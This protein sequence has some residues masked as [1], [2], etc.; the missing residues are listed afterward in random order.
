MS[1][2]LATPAPRPLPHRRV[3]PALFARPSLLP[4]ALPFQ[5]PIDEICEQ[6]APAFLRGTHYLVVALFLAL[7]LIAALT[8]VD[9]VVVASGRIATATPPIVLQPMERAIVRELRVRPGD[10]VTKGEVLATLDP[11]FAEADA[12]ALQTQLRALWA[13]ARRLRAEADGQPLEAGAAPEAD[14]G[15]QT[16]L[17]R[18]RQAEYAARVN[19][20]DA[21]IA[22]LQA[23]LRTLE[24]GRGA[25]GRELDVARAVEDMRSA[26]V[27]SQT[28]SRLNLLEAQAVRLRAERDQLE[29]ANRLPELRH[30]IQ[31][32]EAERQSFIDGWRRDLLDSLVSTRNDIARAVAGLAKAARLHD[33]VVVTAPVDGVVLDVAPR[34]EGSVLRE[35]EPLL[36]IVPKDAPLIAE[37]MIASGDVGYTRAGAEAQIK[38]DAFP[39]QRHGMVA[40]RL[41]SVGE[42]SFSAGAIPETAGGARGG[43]LHRGR[44]ELLDMRLANLPTGARLFPGMTLTAEIKAGSRSVLSYFLYPLTRGLSESV[45]EP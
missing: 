9:V 12:A 8:R 22:R 38:V 36:T 16:A 39:Y 14:D 43:A 2:P 23:S 27:Q 26:L 10:V 1:A 17:Y 4:E 30:G 37:V 45:R 18:Q 35:A 19:A 21:D 5:D 31:S 7:L 11:T 44:V 34:P 3:F 29:A 32:R 25:L 40:G 15:L 42:E 6:P 33:L 41:Q 28:G 13:Q 24:D 20:Y